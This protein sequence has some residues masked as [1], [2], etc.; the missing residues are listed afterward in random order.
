MKL[1]PGLTHSLLV[2]IFGKGRDLLFVF[3][4]LCAIPAESATLHGL[5]TDNMVL[6]RNQ[7]VCV[8]GTGKEGES[9]KVTLDGNFSRATVSEGEW[10]V[11]LPSMEAGGPY[12]LT[13]EGQ[14]AQTL[15]NVMVGDVW[16]CTG[17][18]NMAGTLASY[19]GNRYTEYQHFYEGLPKAN[20][21]IRLF[22]LRQDGADTP[23]RDVVTNEEFGASWRLCDEESASLFSATGYLF[24]HHLQP[25]VGVP[26]GLIY[27]TLGGTKAESW[28]SREVLESRPEFEIILKDYQSAVES[29]PGNYKAY[30]QR[31]ADWRALP[32]AERRE[33]RMP[34]VPMGP[35]HPKRP[36]GLFHYMISPLQ[37]F[38]VAGAIWYQGEGN[39]GR[40]EQYQ[41]LFP[42]LISSWRRQWGI[43]DFPFL[44]V[45]LAAFRAYNPQPEDPDWARLREAQTMTLSL[46]NTGMATIIDAGHQ[47]DIHPPDKPTVGKRLA[48][49][50]LKVAYNRDIVASGPMFRKLEIDGGE[51]TLH[52]DDVGSGLTTRTVETDGLTVPE[53]E[54]SGFAVCG[55][56]REFHWADAKIMGKDRVVVSSPQVQSPVA[57]RYAW[58]NFPRCNLYN[59]EGFPAVPFRTDQFERLGSGTVDG[60]GVGK[61]H[62]GNQPIQNGK[63]G[64]LTDGK[65]GDDNQSAWATNG[66]MNFP[67]HVTVDLEGLHKIETLRIHSS[68]N[69]GT[70]TVE[71]QLSVDGESFS[72]VATTEFDNYKM[73]TYTVLNEK[74][75]PASHVRLVF[76]DIHETSFQ[77]KKNGFIFVRELEIQGNPVA[78]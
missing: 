31:L 21:M 54:L 27:A 68:A 70:K 6:Q 47:T 44:F 23:Q 22:K 58:A 48:A 40:P 64:G 63:W 66:S 26:I 50:A 36:S 8:Y 17:Q 62:V 20:P 71:V 11:T 25:E 30:E 4:F 7:P 67:K 35:D 41:K 56:D 28:V 73:S 3:I 5:F 75:S 69:G 37:Q 29:Y 74:L 14:T 9:I 39:A 12:T 52:F 18:S 38:P 76:P 77:R 49:Q 57:V 1:R 53:G 33:I 32:P 46:P 16:L 43:G 19:M 61:S 51:A 13:V 10:M 34:Q 42:D 60:I 45:Q 55:P 72:T 78:E 2:S 24:G 59:S 65:L 15:R